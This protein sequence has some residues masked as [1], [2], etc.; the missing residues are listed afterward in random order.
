MSLEILQNRYRIKLADD[1]FF[2]V[3]LTN[4]KKFGECQ[5]VYESF[6]GQILN[7]FNENTTVY[8]LKETDLWFSHI[9]I[10]NRSMYSFGIGNPN[11]NDSNIPKCVVDFSMEDL[12]SNCFGAYADDNGIVSVLLR[13]DYS[14]L[15]KKSIKGTLTSLETIQAIENGNQR[16]YMNLGLI[17]TP[18]IIKNIKKLVLEINSNLEDPKLI[19]DTKETEEEHHPFYFD[20]LGL[21]PKSFPGNKSK[22]ELFNSNNESEQ[23]NSNSQDKNDFCVLCG[24]SISNVKLDSKIEILKKTNPDKCNDCLEKIHAAHG[25]SELKKLVSIK[26]FNEKTI[27]SK[28]KEPET[29]KSYFKILKKLNL[30]KDF[31]KDVYLFNQAKDIDKFI[32]KYGNYF[33]V[34]TKNKITTKKPEESEKTET[35]HC[36]VCGEKL[37]LD[38]FYKSD[39]FP[40]G[41]GTICKVCSRKFHAAKAINNIRTFVDPATPFSKEDLLNQSNNRMVFLDYF[42]TLQ[43]F[44]LLD[45]DKKPDYY[46][47]KSEKILDEFVEKYGDKSPGKPEP[48]PEKI[49]NKK[50]TTKLVKM[51]EICNE[52]LPISDFYKTMDS[53]DG[54][55]VKC[56]DCSRKS[57]AAKALK[58]LLNCVEPG[59]LFYRKDLLDQCEN[60]IQFKDY[61]WTLQ[62][63]D[64]LDH[65]EK[66]DS[67]ILK[68][69]NVIDQFINKYGAK[70]IK[71]KKLQEKK[72]NPEQIPVEIETAKKTIKTCTTC[73]EALPVSDFYKSSINEDGLLNNCK[74]CSE[75][76]NASKILVEIQ[77]YVEFGKPFTQTELSNKINNE[78]KANYY[79]WTLQEQDLLKYNEKTDT[80]LLEENKKFELNK[81]EDN[82]TKDEFKD[83]PTELNKET[84]KKFPKHVKTTKTSHVGDVDSFSKKEIIYISDNNGSTYS[85]IILK[86][87]IKNDQ[88]IKTFTSL[89]SLIKSNINKILVHR[90]LEYYSEVMIDLEIK[91]ESVEDT[92]LLLKDAKWEKN[93]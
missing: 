80:Y 79:I 35:K 56:K 4:S 17:N 1:D 73:G 15:R 50:K 10:K 29:F 26:L 38:R 48:T 75:K 69:E 12:D 31:T 91:K 6:N 77:E 72:R 66:N 34:E 18:K 58:A 55:S 59:I 41:L 32:E 36:E 44:N 30:I 39:D 11:K 22:K 78:T 45:E 49:P 7:N 64:L 2:K 13:V 76:T 74:S 83:T 65:D 16:Y 93:K 20:K 47:L 60:Q 42:W 81:V 67:Y 14:K 85:T 24:K 43:E 68:P 5:V 84:I 62:E 71:D 9:Q 88:L 92:L 8:S 53:E 3:L 87:I 33:E 63:F 54:Y 89:E 90:H 82:S 57:Y 19:F 70:S 46:I 23:I 40:D 27:S 51:C 21:K 28:V 52:K 37:D 25:L 61:C 86:G